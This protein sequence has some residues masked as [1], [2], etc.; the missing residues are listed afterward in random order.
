MKL[1]PTHSHP[2]SSLALW[3]SFFSEPFDLFAP[4]LRAADRSGRVRNPSVP[5]SGRPVTWFENDEEHIARV[6]LPGV[7]REDLKVEAEEGLVRLVAE[8][9]SEETRKGAEGESEGTVR[10]ST[11]SQYVLRIPE[12]VDPAAV[13]ATL[14][15]GI[16]ELKLPKPEESKPVSVEI[17]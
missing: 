6:E 7:R 16:L 13:S 3:D 14:R 1:I 12:G 11:R 8:R 5:E 15:D 9:A 2:S 10:E 17:Q 4:L